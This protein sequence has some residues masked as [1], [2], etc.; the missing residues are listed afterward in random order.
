MTLEHATFFNF[1]FDMQNKLMNL[2]MPKKGRTKIHKEIY[3]IDNTSLIIF[4]LV[5]EICVRG[6][7]SCFLETC[8]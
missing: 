6:G 5:M 2:H 7:I 3:S 4:V 1:F 8:H